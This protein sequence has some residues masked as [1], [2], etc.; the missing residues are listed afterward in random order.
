MRGSDDGTNLKSNSNHKVKEVIHYDNDDIFGVKIDDDEDEDQEDQP[1]INNL[2]EQQ[3]L[4]LVV[5]IP[6]NHQ[7][8][9]S[10][11]KTENEPIKLKLKLNTISTDPIV[12]IS[13]N[14]NQPLNESDNES[15]NVIESSYADQD[16][17]KFH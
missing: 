11:N 6:K 14:I 5:K 7:T 16:F 3:P 8:T 13:N 1:V 2:N 4:R 10:A 9:S 17:G 12:N 15:D